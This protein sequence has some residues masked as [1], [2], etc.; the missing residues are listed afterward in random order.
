VSHTRRLVFD[1][2]E[3]IH[4]RPDG[5]LA[6][7]NYGVSVADV[8]KP[9]GALAERLGLERLE[10]FL[11]PPSTYLEID[12]L[13]EQVEVAEAR[14]DAA[15]AGKLRARLSK[16]YPSHDPSQVRAVVRS[17]AAHLQTSTAESDRDLADIV[18]F[19]LE[20]YDHAL[21]VAVAENRRVFI[22]PF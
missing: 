15:R 13:S 10:R 1:N 20:A 5:D 18:L 16:L 4:L 11:C 7:R 8:W 21:A 9:L 3:P 6:Y 2:G 19:D 17:L 12:D 22:R 14:G